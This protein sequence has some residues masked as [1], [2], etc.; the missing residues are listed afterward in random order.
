MI[1]D[2]TCP[3]AWANEH[4]LLEGTP[5][6][7][8]WCLSYKRAEVLGLQEP[9]SMCSDLLLWQHGRITVYYTAFDWVNITAKV[10][11][12][13]ITPGLYQSIAALREI[14]RCLAEGMT[15]E[16]ALKCADAVG[17]FSGPMRANLVAMLDG[18]GIQDA[19][20]I[21]STA[22][23]FDSHHEMA[24]LVSAI[25]FPVFVSNKNY[26]GNSPS[27]VKDPN[28]RSL[29]RGC[30]GA[31]VRMVPHALVIPLGQAA[32]N[33]VEML[34]DEGLITPERCL[35]GFPHPSGGNGWRVRQYRDRRESLRMSVLRAQTR[36]SSPPEDVR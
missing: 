21:T 4:G 3:V 8:D 13:G 11:L 22:Q 2:H 15:N 34:I 9:L 31:R 35:L 20:G 1:V 14:R 25:D 12:V 33:A 27:L 19:L 7:P 32:S 18:I 28:L 23:L 24:A 29:V 6:K 26:G 16:E 36:L 10:M 17:S 5:V 30:L